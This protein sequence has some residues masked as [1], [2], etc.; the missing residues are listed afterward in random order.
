MARL[1]I[2]DIRVGF[3]FKAKDVDETGNWFLTEIINVRQDDFTVRE[4]DPRSDSRGLEYEIPN[5]EF[6]DITLYKSN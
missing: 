3:K 4:I 6:S 2:G 1:S 5:D